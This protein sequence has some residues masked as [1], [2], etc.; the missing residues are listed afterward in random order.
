[1]VAT[2]AA[3]KDSFQVTTPSEQEILMTR[4]FNAPRHLVFE[5]MTKPEHVKRWWGC[6]GTGYSVP[7]CEI[8]L[9]PG[10]AW[11]FVNRHPH[12]EA[13][14]HGE[15]K[16]ITPP[17]RLVYTEIFEMYPDTVSLV[18]SVLTDEGGKTRVTTTTRYP[19]KEVRDA[20]IASGMEHGAALSYDRLE[21]L[22][23]QLQQR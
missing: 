1:M 14:F 16:E 9:R 2:S 18:T 5:A 8:D 23:A 15:Y 21:D 19:S 12:G 22:V 20:V 11:R 13:A 7:V 4:L 10:G 3:N 17:S 6:L